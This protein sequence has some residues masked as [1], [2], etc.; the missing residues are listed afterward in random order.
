M[1]NDE[2]IHK[3]L[4]Q[5]FK[6]WGICCW[7]LFSQISLSQTVYKIVEFENEYDP[8]VGSRVTRH[9]EPL[10]FEFELNESE[11]DSFRI[12]RP[13][14]KEVRK[15]TSERYVRIFPSIFVRIARKPRK[16]NA[17]Y[18]LYRKWMMTASE[19]RDTTVH[20]TD[21]Y[22]CFHGNS[23]PD[24]SY[25]DVS[26]G[27]KRHGFS[28]SKIVDGQEEWV[29]SHYSGSQV[30]VTDDLTRFRARH[31]ISLLPFISENHRRLGL[32][33]TSLSLNYWR[34]CVSDN[35]EEESHQDSY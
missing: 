18:A 19:M 16:R 5:T 4:R 25:L 35:L 15:L 12:S 31:E 21:V 26:G 2:K 20:I 9:F 29:L 7:I 10:S 6:F 17:D 24:T 33:K 34:E 27:G 8:K 13:T 22:E 1:A 3:R 28:I 23:A 32:N 11:R 14:E 30:F